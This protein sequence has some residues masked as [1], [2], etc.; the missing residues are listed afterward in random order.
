MFA[1]LLAL[2]TLGLAV[3]HCSSTAR[4]HSSPPTGGSGGA[5]GQAGAGG[6]GGAGNTGGTAASDAG[7]GGADAGSPTPKLVSTHLG[8][9]PSDQFVSHIA[10]SPSSEHLYVSGY[11]NAGK[12]GFVAEFA[13][14][15][16]PELNRRSFPSPNGAFYLSSVVIDGNDELELVGMFTKD[17]N[18]AGQ[19]STEAASNGFAGVV[20]RV[21][22]TPDGGMSA[23]SFSIAGPG[24]QMQRDNAPFG[25]GS[26]SV[27]HF[28]GTTEVHG[29]SL[30]ATGGP[31]ALVSIDFQGVTAGKHAA[32]GGAGAQYFFGVV[33][34]GTSEVFA[35][36]E[37]P[38]T[39]TSLNVIA[40]TNQLASVV[41]FDNQLQQKWAKGLGSGS[42]DS[43]FDVALS[44]T[45]APPF[46]VAVGV[47]KGAIQLP[48][49]KLLDYSGGEDVLVARF[50]KS[51]NLD[52][53][54][55]FG[56][57]ADDRAFSVAVTK[58]G[59][60]F[61]AAQ[62][63]SASLDVGGATLQKHGGV[64]DGLLLRLDAAGNVLWAELVGGAGEDGFNSLTIGPSGQ[65]ALAGRF[66]GEFQF[67]GKT[68]TGAPLTD[69]VWDFA[70]LVLD[71]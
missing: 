39:G 20:A 68:I 14:A 2:P 41:C 19:I 10:I 55:S 27:G 26:V 12:E 42:N 13:S 48:G 65:L 70:L 61:V 3:S 34:D 43:F 5:A 58:T 57:S 21:L 18:I 38:D 31:D 8:K 52:W 37:S 51:G 44:P 62:I 9:S 30:S 71:P 36:G 40:G 33:A 35:V 64:S 28:A 60:I 11:R 46:L 56:G 15:S 63:K 69:K 23:T 24:D 54:R 6:N 50:D 16:A 53:A 22:P 32:F 29:Q 66:Q 1:S 7:L 49:G 59:D 25:T 4:N 45:G 17:V 67:L 47:T